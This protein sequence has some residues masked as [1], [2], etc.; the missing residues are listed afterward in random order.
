MNMASSS[1]LTRARTTRLTGERCCVMASRSSWG[2]SSILGLYD[3]DV[4][5]DSSLTVWGGTTTGAG[6]GVDRPT[7]MAVLSEPSTGTGLAIAGNDRTDRVD[8]IAAVSTSPPRLEASN[9]RG[10]GLRET[11]VKGL[12]MMVLTRRHTLL[13]GRETAVSALS[14]QGRIKVAI[15]KAEVDV[16]TTE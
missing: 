16:V 13:V 6:V 2:R 15:A 9:D 1:L 4:V 11:R 12:L 8:F 5:P 14:D 3:D 7:D 10:A